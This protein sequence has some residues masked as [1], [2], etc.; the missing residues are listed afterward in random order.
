MGVNI[1]WMYLDGHASAFLFV[2]SFA[3]LIAGVGFTVAAGLMGAA[4]GGPLPSLVPRMV[5][6]QFIRVTVS[7]THTSGPN[8][9][10]GH[11]IKNM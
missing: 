8:L 4:L 9:R 5:T 10:R 6:V 2:S 3:A 11:I 7:T 1:Q